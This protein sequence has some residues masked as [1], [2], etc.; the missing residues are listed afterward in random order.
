MPVM[1]M[2]APQA[3]D[4]V[5]IAKDKLSKNLPLTSEE[6]RI[7]APT[8]MS[9]ARQMR[10]AAP[11]QNPLSALSG[12]TG[13]KP[14]VPTQ[15]QGFQGP[16]G[17]APL[18]MSG[19]LWDQAETAALPKPGV[20]I[21]SEDRVVD[22]RPPLGKITT[23]PPSGPKPVAQRP[24]PPVTEPGPE[25]VVSSAFQ[26]AAASTG[27][28]QLAQATQAKLNEPVD[29]ATAK[30]SLDAFQQFLTKHPDG[31]TL[32]NILDAVGVSLSAYGGTQRKT[33]L[34]SQREAEM[35]LAQQKTLSGQGFEQSKELQQ[36]GFGQQN[37]IQKAQFTQ[38]LAIK[39]QELENQKQLL[40]QEYQNAIAQ[41]NNA[42]AVAIKNRLIE[43]EAQKN[44]NIEQERAVHAVGYNL[45][46]AVNKYSGA[47]Q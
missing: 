4:P 27:D 41:G 43:I 39:R 45:P 38:E 46:S 37:A 24:I 7:V 36:I 12:Q 13:P 47:P 8:S 30:K 44:A 16:A 6:A 3:P 20:P 32:A 15:P 14:V 5:A 26:A 42:A 28:P 17:S 10:N 23:P 25:P 21:G 34:Q 1:P 9:E 11:A 22:A 2:Q 19:R 31:L 33:Q 35:Q 18:G 29:P 40:T